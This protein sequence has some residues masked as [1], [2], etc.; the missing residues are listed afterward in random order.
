[1]TE[2]CSFFLL[3]LNED[4]SE[5]QPAIRLWAI[6]EEGRRVLIQATQIRPYFYYLPDEKDS[7][8]LVRDQLLKAREQF[9]KITGIE[10]ETKRLL[11]HTRRVLKITC[12]DSQALISSARK[13]RKDLG[14]GHTFEEDLRLSVRYVTDTDLKPCAWHE[15]NVEP[16]DAGRANVDRAFAAK[17]IPTSIKDDKMPA[18]RI[19]AFTILA[20]GEKG[21]ARPER[22]PVRAIGVA[23]SQAR[24]DVLV[25][26]GEDDS[27]VLTDFVN[28]VSKFDP[29]I[30]VG[31]ESN[32]IAWPYLMERSKF[33]KIKLNVGRDESEPHTSL[34]GH[35]SLAG[36]ANVD[37]FEVA[38]GMQEVKVKT[39]ENVA[40]FLQIPSA[41]KI[42]TIE[43][44]ERYQLW[45]DESGRERLVQNA[46]TNAQALLE[47][48]E[49]TINYPIQLSALTR[50]P[51]DQV[52]AAAVG[53]RVD[54][55]L[56][57][58]AHMIGELIPTRIEQPFYTY[59]GALVL[60]PK[61]GLHDNIVVL[62]FSS[63][64]PNL[65][66]KYNLSPDTLVRPGEIVSED[67]VFM[68][69][70]VKHRFRKKPDGFYR[71]VLSTLIQQ[72]EVIKKEMEGLEEKSTRY[73]VLRERE[74]AVKI[75][76]NACYGYAGW[77]GA[78]WYA[79]EVAES[80]TALGREVIHKTIEEAESLGLNV[81]YGDT[82][83]I[84]VRDDP[85]KVRQLQAWAER[86][87]GLDIRRERE[88]TRILFT[89]A[90][91]RYAG[92]L[93]KGSLDIVGLEV[94]RGDWSD[95][96]RQVQEQ[97]L[98]RILRDQS[99]EKAIDDVQ[100]TIRR[101]RNGEVPLAD[102]TIRKTLT[103]PIEDYAVRTPHVEVAKLLVKQGWDLAVGDKVAY[104]V[105]KGSGKLFQKAK[106]SSQ[107][108]PEDVDIDYYLDNQ[109]K[110]AAMRILER[111]GVTGK[112]L[113]A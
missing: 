58:Q 44:S 111:F 105:T 96:A 82:D 42:K 81:I 36:R 95:I 69:P 25:A 112:Q 104:V 11:G 40:E 68:I 38:G 6:D 75:V 21:S 109:I 80:A 90:M 84:F 106:P 45:K 102:L 78:R 43:E 94:V 72:R 76:T 89:E 17:S 26:K 64:Y 70:E 53:F 73:R 41:G 61:T 98:T 79:K 32:S 52:M 27:Q 1:L 35:V 103:K 87:F 77:A 65:M 55:Y 18:F 83:S 7:L 97:V 29:D 86:E 99:T 37:V 5:G 16:T 46:K 51:L 88:F 57:K 28:L 24:F 71:I 101:L 63:M 47:L 10:T 31:F 66:E 85:E 100:T 13:V 54:S 23:T 33:R 59:R 15:C 93:R 108:K 12:S 30:V 113:T 91:K 48:A 3:D 62:D 4:R 2:K 92:L 22:D 67:S 60:E 19:L 49:V 14:T 74:R 20:V 34:Y 56:I 110:P 107:A 39:L 9:P 50:L 8:D